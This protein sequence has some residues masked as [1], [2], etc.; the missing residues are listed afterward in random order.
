MVKVLFPLQA[1]TT[2]FHQ[3]IDLK[4][5]NGMMCSCSRAETEQHS[6]QQIAGG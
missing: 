4:I 6:L 5:E 2:H 3:F 1:A